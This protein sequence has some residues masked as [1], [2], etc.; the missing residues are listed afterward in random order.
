[1]PLGPWL[2]EAHRKAPFVPKDQL[3]GWAGIGTVLTAPLTCNTSVMPDGRQNSLARWLREQPSILRFDSSPR[4][5]S[6][7]DL[8]GVR[9]LGEWKRDWSLRFTRSESAGQCVTDVPVFATKDNV[10]VNPEALEKTRGVLAGTLAQGPA[11]RV[12]EGRPDADGQIAT[13]RLDHAGSPLENDFHM[14]PHPSA[15]APWAVTASSASVLEAAGTFR[16]RTAPGD[17]PGLDLIY[18]A[19]DGDPARGVLRVRQNGPEA[20]L[21][22]APPIGGDVSVQVRWKRR[23][24]TT[25]NWLSISRKLTDAASQLAQ[26]RDAVIGDTGTKQGWQP[27]W[28][29]QILAPAWQLTPGSGEFP[30]CVRLRSER[31]F[32]GADCGRR[33]MDSVAA[34][35]RG[36]GGISGKNTVWGSRRPSRLTLDQGKSL[37]SRVRFGCHTEE[38]DA[39]SGAVVPDPAHFWEV[40]WQMV[41]GSWNDTVLTVT[42]MTR[43]RDLLPYAQEL[44]AYLDAY[45]DLALGYDPDIQFT[46]VA[47]AY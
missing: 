5:S 27:V 43:M 40:Q 32:Q 10:I 12:R 44:Q 9:G 14:P 41:D 45:C 19:A 4:G 23:L 36:F 3:L 6:T 28:T 16:F 46:T 1:M 34:F 31:G 35:R 42:G 39:V 11:L 47:I 29:D 7:L 33:A 26:F 20:C 25:L 37:L 38:S 21:L 30:V 2:D 17:E 15:A 22:D 24:A 13:I 18:L 8:G